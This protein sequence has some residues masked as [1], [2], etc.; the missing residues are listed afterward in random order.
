MLTNSTTLGFKQ[1]TL[2]IILCAVSLSCFPQDS[3]P[4]DPISLKAKMIETLP[5]ENRVIDAPES[6]EELYDD[7][8]IAEI[9]T[10]ADLDT[11]IE[12]QLP[13]V[14]DI[15]REICKQ[16]NESEELT[17]NVPN[18]T[19]GIEPEDRPSI[20]KGI[21]FTTVGLVRTMIDLTHPSEN[22]PDDLNEIKF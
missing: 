16:I 15:E 18:G 20:E 22:D 5:L 21:Y 9:T 13:K 8:I 11:L 4:L 19:Y 6:F 12:N 17:A 2:I 14:L 10:I 1:L 7:L 3:D